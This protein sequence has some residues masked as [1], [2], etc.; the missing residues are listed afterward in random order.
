[1]KKEPDWEVTITNAVNGFIVSYNTSLED[2]DN[3]VIR[4]KRKVFENIDEGELEAMENVLWFLIEHFGKSG[5]RYDKERLKIVREP[6]DK[7]ES[8]KKQ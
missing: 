3:D 1:M 4:T 5:S 8:T 7:Y 6:G 2:G